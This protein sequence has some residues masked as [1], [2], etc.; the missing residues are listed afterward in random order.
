LGIYKTLAKHVITKDKDAPPKPASEGGIT[1]GQDVLFLIFDLMS[2]A[3]IHTYLLK[4]WRQVWTIFIEKENGNPDINCLRCLMLFEVD[5]QLLLK[6]HSSYGF[7]PCTEE[8][9]MLIAV[10]GRQERM[11]RNR[12]SNATDCRNGASPPPTNTS[13]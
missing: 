8:A 12:P 13:Y 9:G 10:Q 7:L 4:R 1:Q 11:Q 2:I 3:L 5:W 6:W